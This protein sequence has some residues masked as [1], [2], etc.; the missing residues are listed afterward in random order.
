MA[1]GLN[2]DLYSDETWRAAH[3][4]EY[5]AW[6]RRVKSVHGAM[7]GRSPKPWKPI[8]AFRL[9]DESGMRF[10]LVTLSNNLKKVRIH[11]PIPLAC[12]RE[13]EWPPS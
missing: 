7:P 2:E 10:E 8:R 12:L 6:E 1:I 4:D 9:L 3:L 11:V 13:I 5:K